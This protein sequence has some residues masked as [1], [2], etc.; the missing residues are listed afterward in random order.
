LFSDAAQFHERPMSW[1]RSTMLLV[2]AEAMR[3]LV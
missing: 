1:L 3:L 2:T